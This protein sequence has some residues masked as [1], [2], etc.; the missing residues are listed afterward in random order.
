M[1]GLFVIK[2]GKFIWNLVSKE[3]RKQVLSYVEMSP[4]SCFK[5]NMFISLVLK[6]ASVIVVSNLYLTIS[7]C[8]IIT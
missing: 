1:Q 3:T 7:Y 4:F 6:P 8:K 5:E 2:N